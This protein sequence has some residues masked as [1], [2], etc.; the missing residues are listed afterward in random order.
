M[1]LVLMINDK[2][3]FSMRLIDFFFILIFLILIVFR[4]GGERTK[5][6]REEKMVKKLLEGDTTV[7][8][9]H[10]GGSELKWDNRRTGRAP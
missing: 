5:E 1:Y 2:L 6:E 8:F 4:G 10:S 7:G 9:I 3:I